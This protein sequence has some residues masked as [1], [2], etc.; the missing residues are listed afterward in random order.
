MLLWLDRLELRYEPFPI[1]LIRPIL[2]NDCYLSY[3]DAYPPP[4]LFR[5][6]PKVGNK[7]LLSEKF[8]RDG[9]FDWIRN[10]PIW[11]DFYHWIKSDDFIYGV[12]NMLREQY[13]DLGFPDRSMQARFGRRMRRLLRGRSWR[14]EDGL[15]ARFDFSIMPADGGLLLPHT[16]NPEKIITLVISMVRPGEWSP[17]LGGGL[18]INRPRSPELAFNHLNRKAGFADMDILHTFEFAPNQGIL[19]V[20]TF[21]SWHSVRPMTATGS[22]ALRRTLTINIEKRN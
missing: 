14:G 17:D 22:T 21:N 11:K 8:N 15:S 9:Y 20:K 16:D 19:F 10:R 6:F 4:H 13:I 5:P 3:V 2:P 18:D 1:G 12:L 7:S